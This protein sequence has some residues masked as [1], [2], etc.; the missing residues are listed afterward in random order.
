MGGDINEIAGDG[1]M[2]IFQG[3][4]P[5]Q[6]ALSATAAAMAI[7]AVTAALQQEDPTQP[8]AVHMGL[9]SGVALVGLTCLKGQHGTRWTFTAR[10]P[11]TNLAARL[12]D[13][14]KPGQIL[15]GPE[16]VRRLGQRYHFQKLG[17][18]RFKNMAEPID[19]YGLQGP[20]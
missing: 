2:A 16:T 17:C 10:G 20:A 8:I 5:Q 1:L 4:S 3:V 6:H 19:I 13:G 15:L 14:A 7:L 11:M 12:A 18:E 9:N